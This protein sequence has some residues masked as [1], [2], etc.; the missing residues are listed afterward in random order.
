MNND[1]RIAAV[2]LVLFMSFNL[3]FYVFEQILG[4]PA[5]T[6]ERIL[7]LMILTYLVISNDK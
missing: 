3:L 1:L 7:L 4:M 5:S 2:R 6:T